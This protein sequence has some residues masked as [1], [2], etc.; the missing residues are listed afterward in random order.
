MIPR[1]LPHR[2]P[3]GSMI[4]IAVLAALALYVWE[5]ATDAE[6]GAR[7]LAMVTA[8]IAFDAIQRAV[9]DSIFYAADLTGTSCPFNF[10]EEQPFSLKCAILGRNPP[11]HPN[12]AASETYYIV[13]NL[14]HK[15]LLVVGLGIVA[16]YMSPGT[17][18]RVA[19]WLTVGMLVVEVMRVAGAFPAK[20]CMFGHPSNFNTSK[21]P[22]GAPDAPA[23]CY[24]RGTLKRGSNGKDYETSFHGWKVPGS[25]DFPPLPAKLAPKKRKSKSKKSS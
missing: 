5:S 16:G 18:G 13:E 6:A 21:Q 23:L 7:M 24:P 2:P 25:S 11:G 9:R 1:M 15:A 14:A 10:G 22:K 20:Q 4:R 19:R 8:Y 3:A 12:N 17:S